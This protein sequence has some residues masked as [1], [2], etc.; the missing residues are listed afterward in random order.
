MH[1]SVKPSFKTKNEDYCNVLPPRPAWLSPPNG[2]TQEKGKK[3]WVS[4]PICMKLGRQVSQE[5]AQVD[6]HL[7]RS[8][9]PS[10]P[11]LLPPLPPSLDIMSKRW[12]IL[13]IRESELSVHGSGP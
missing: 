3:E 9:M 5:R 7:S 2:P 11:L 6:I 10:P 8:C 13:A 4:I 12:L 1:K